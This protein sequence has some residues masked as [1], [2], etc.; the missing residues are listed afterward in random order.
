MLKI[1]I[2]LYRCSMCLCLE[3]TIWHFLT[4]C[5]VRS[6]FLVTTSWQLCQNNRVPT[7]YWKYW[8]SIEFQT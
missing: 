4:F 7:C 8:K 3:T 6:I 5:R 1:G 2:V